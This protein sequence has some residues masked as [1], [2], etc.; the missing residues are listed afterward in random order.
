MDSTPLG[1]FVDAY[2]TRDR[3]EL[4]I[5]LLDNMIW[6]VLVAGFVVFSLL[7][8]GV[9]SS[10][11]N[12]QFLFFS[13]AA[14]G[15]LTLAE[16]ICLLSGNFDLSVGSI[17]GF[18]AMFSALFLASWVPDAPGVVGVLVA[19]LVGAAI[20]A[21]NGISVAYIGVNPFLQ[22]LSFFII[23]RGGVVI[24]STTTVFNLPES[25]T[26]LGGGTLAGALPAAIPLVIILFLIAGFFLRYTRMGMSIIAT[27]GDENSAMEAGIDTQRVTLMTFTIS[28]MLSG[29][30]GVLYAGFVGSVTPGLADGALFS[31]F[32]A[33]II[34]GMSLFGGRG[35]V[36][37]A[38]GG[39]LLLSMINTGL[40]QLEVD[41][42]AIQTVTGLVLLGAIILYTLESRIRTRVLSA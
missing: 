33:A 18:S 29:L 27:G 5:F 8:P 37:G 31:A 38:F 9:F 7:L 20:G 32:A 4:A 42:E 39:V 11:A 2:A 26:Y 12:I 16:S 13:S 10:S 3:T 25:F 30:A 1:T 24:L 17:A 41:P 21:M 22:T 15:V 28:G 40:V 35:K 14:L 6:P 23:W 19:L 34:G 36:T